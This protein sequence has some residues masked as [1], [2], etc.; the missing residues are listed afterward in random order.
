MVRIQL[1]YNW[2]IVNHLDGF[3]IRIPVGKSGYH[4]GMQY[5]ECTK[6]VK[7]GGYWLG[8]CHDLTVI[9]QRTRVI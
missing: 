6:E 4:Y 1:E 8:I 5:C 7:N 3:F 9:N 2:D